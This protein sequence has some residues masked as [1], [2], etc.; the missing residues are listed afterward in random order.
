MSSWPMGRKILQH[1]WLALF[2]FSLTLGQEYLFYFLKDL[3]IHFLSIEK[4]LSI[5][6]LFFLATFIAPKLW[7][8]FF[9]TLIMFLNYFQMAHLSYF[10]TQ[11]IPIEIYLLFSQFHEITGTA[12]VEI[13]HIFTPLILTIVPASFAYFVIERSDKLYGSKIVLLVFFSMTF[14]HPVS[15]YLGDSQRGLNALD[16]E[17]SGLNVYWSLSY[18][19]GKILP[20][21]ISG[22]PKSS[23]FN[24][25]SHLTLTP[26]NEIL[27]DSII[28]IQGESLSPHHMSLFDYSRST[29]PFLENQKNNPHFFYTTGLASAVATDVSVAFFFNLG[30]GDAGRTKALI[31]EHC[32]F[33]LAKE[34]KLKTYFY[35]SQTKDQLKFITPYIC[36][37]FVDDFKS[38]EIIS[39]TTFDDQ[40]ADDKEILPFL[41]KILPLKEKQFIVLHQ[42]GSHAPWERRSKKENRLFPH[43]HKINHYDNS[44]VE[45]DLFMEKL[46]KI[47]LNSGKKI[48][49]IYTSDHGEAMG[50]GGLWG[51]GQLHRL[52]FEVPIIIQSYNSP[53]PNSVSM[54]PKFLTHY[55]L[56]L[57]ITQAMGL[58]ANQKLHLIPSD[59][60]IYGNDL[61]GF[62]GEA[63]ILFQPNQ[64][65]DFE[66]IN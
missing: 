48:L 49:V 54:F 23:R 55:N 10:G 58:E 52:S 5:Y 12:F 64:T 46:H 47:I 32:L 24:S 13:G 44:V 45:F 51:H 11:I 22:T 20:N 50:Q 62:G 2:I 57:F 41:E 29:T 17:L 27:W 9:L 63:K 40:A 15:A 53:L 28:F 56:A 35:S 18:F 43:N 37:D 66:V 30:F 26:S 6:F 4:Y 8:H 36:K 21:K 1:L 60:T 16:N 33:K 3:K 34:Q 31:G 65:Y 42:R 7:R 19:S 25:S 38:L 39:P 59:F 14:Y 61:D